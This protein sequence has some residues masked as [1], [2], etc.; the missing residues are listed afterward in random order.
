MFI[1]VTPEGYEI[2]NCDGEDAYKAEPT[3]F[4]TVL[5]CARGLRVW[6]KGALY[7]LPCGAVPLRAACYLLAGVPWGDPA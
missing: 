6:S 3:P 4:V 1:P 2:W 5:F 7:R